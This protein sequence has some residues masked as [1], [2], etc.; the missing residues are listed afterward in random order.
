MV[1]LVPM[2]FLFLSTLTSNGSANST[3][4]YSIVYFCA[5]PSL[6]FFPASSPAPY[7]SLSKSSFSR[8]DDLCS[9]F[10]GCVPS[11]S[12][13]TCLSRLARQG[14]PAGGLTSYLDSA[15]QLSG[16]KG[17]CLDRI[18]L[19]RNGE[20]VP[21]RCVLD[22]HR[23]VFLHFCSAPVSEPPLREIAFGRGFLW[24]LETSLRLEE[25]IARLP[26]CENLLNS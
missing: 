23:E 5:K 10:G 25:A 17:P 4:E 26:C 3:A 14:S 18:A 11:T 22:W 1:T 21:R 16:L 2:L 12:S 13:K 8:F 19:I 24:T 9:C 7:S 20:R 15:S 6:D